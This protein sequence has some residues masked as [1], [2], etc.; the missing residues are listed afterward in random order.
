M[1][2]GP[3][4]NQIG[5]PCL[6][7]PHTM[8]NV[9]PPISLYSHPNNTV[10]Q[11]YKVYRSVQIRYSSEQLAST[12][13][14]PLQWFFFRFQSPQLHL[15]HSDNRNLALFEIKIQLN[16]NFPPEKGTN[17]RRIKIYVSCRR[18]EGDGSCCYNF[19]EIEIDQ[20]WHTNTHITIPP[21]LH[22][23]WE[24]QIPITNKPPPSQNQQLPHFLDSRSRNK[25]EIDDKKNFQI[26]LRRGRRRRR[27]S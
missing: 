7:S 1:A 6:P 10:T 16:A 4:A 21:P 13:D 3:T 12:F 19:P 27:R 26:N 14:F 20:F 25:T 15:V 18:E 24:I 5:D 9:S 22:L 8:R 23:F 17:E 2:A 11:H